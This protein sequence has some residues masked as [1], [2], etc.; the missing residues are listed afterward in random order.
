MGLTVFINRLLFQ[1]LRVQ[2]RSIEKGRHVSRRCDRKKDESQ[3]QVIKYQRFGLAT[4]QKCL[5]LTRQ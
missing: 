3:S 5:Y 2:A 4:N 1:S